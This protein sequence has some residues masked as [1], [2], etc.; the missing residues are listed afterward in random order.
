[1]NTQLV[2]QH[3]EWMGNTS[4]FTQLSGKRFLYGLIAKKQ[5]QSHNFVI[6]ITNCPLSIRELEEQAN[7]LYKSSRLVFLEQIVFVKNRE[8]VKVLARK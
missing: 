3:I 4:Y 5:K 6:D 7:D 2:V 8:I 1:M